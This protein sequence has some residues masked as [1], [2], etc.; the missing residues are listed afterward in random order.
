MDFCRSR[1]GQTVE[2]VKLSKRFG[3]LRAVENLD[4]VLFLVQL[5]SPFWDSVRFCL[6]FS[7]TQSKKTLVGRI[8]HL[9]WGDV[10]GRNLCTTGPQRC[11]EDDDAWNALWFDSSQQRSLLRL[12]LGSTRGGAMKK[13][14]SE[15]ILR[16]LK[17]SW[18]ILRY[19]EIS[20]DILS[21]LWLRGAG[22]GK[23]DSPIDLVEWV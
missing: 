14:K 19:L 7:V 8:G 18:D 16:Y 12:R 10:P 20:W 15:R 13:T 2:I 6:F 5:G 11:R 17:I 22:A 4:L 21:M 3:Q 9:D 23:A 1:N